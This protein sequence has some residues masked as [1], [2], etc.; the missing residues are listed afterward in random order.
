[1]GKPQVAYKP[2]RVPLDKKEAILWT[3]TTT[4]QTDT[5]PSRLLYLS[6]VPLE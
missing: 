3:P 2:S 5:A 4:G 6:Q 1:M